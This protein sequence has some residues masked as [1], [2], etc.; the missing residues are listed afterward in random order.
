MRELGS[1]IWLEAHQ[2]YAVPRYTEARAVLSDAE[3]FCSGQ[4]VGLNEVANNFGAGLTTMMSDGEKHFYLR[5]IM[6]HG[7]APRALRNLRIDV[8]ALA[9]NRVAELVEQGSFDAVTDLARALPLAVVPDLL[10]WP[11][12]RRQQLLEWAAASFD[13]PAPK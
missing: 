3:T 12:G 4:G 11:A 2:I 7:F 6:M 10:G 9:T 1:V 13:F 5:G 8:E